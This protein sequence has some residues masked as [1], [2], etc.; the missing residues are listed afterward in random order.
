MQR[1]LD[2]LTASRVRVLLG[3]AVCVLLSYT[4]LIPMCVPGALPGA[5][6]V[7]LALRA[8]QPGADWQAA[9][10]ATGTLAWLLL[11][12]GAGP[13]A[14]VLAGV[15]L[16]GP[17]LLVGRLL[18]RGGS[19]ALAFQLTVLA[20]LLV[21]GAVHVL[22]ADPAGVWQPLVERFAAELDRFAAT[23]ANGGSDWHPST[24][25]LH[26]AAAAIV[27]W[28]AVA[29][30]TLLNAMAAACLGLYLHGRQTG[31]PRLGPQFRALKAGRTIA[32]VAL[33]LVAVAIGAHS[34]FATD[35]SWVL[36]G[37]FGLQGLSLLHAAREALGFGT[38]VLAATYVLMFVPLVSVA[39]QSGLV[40]FGYFDNWLPLRARL[41]ALGARIKARQG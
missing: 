37:A 6:V 29:W 33:A 22:L 11:P 4:L 34:G 30:L 17:P 18:A 19:L 28:G 13:V 20:T 40:I 26:A 32:V 25:E 36:L 12:L 9:L 23:M 16:I 8:D 31:Q 5:F 1:L 35:A 24:A 21:L 10:V 38:A 7:W 41:G 3:A 39:V 14:T 2:W 15:S 27:S